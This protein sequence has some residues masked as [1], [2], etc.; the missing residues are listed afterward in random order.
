MYRFNDFNTLSKDPKSTPQFQAATGAAAREQTLRTVINHL[1]TEQKSY[2]DLHTTQ[3]TFMTPEL[4]SVYEIA[5]PQGWVPYTEPP[6]SQ[7]VGLLSQVSFLALHAH[8]GRSS[9]TLRG[10]ALRETLLCQEVPPPPPNVDFSVLNNPDANYPTQRD[11]VRA[12]LENPSC[13]GCHLIIDPIGLALENFDGE[14]RFRLRENG[15][16]IDASGELDG[17]EFDD[18]PGLAHALKNNPAL[19]KCLVQRMYYYSLGG[20]TV[21]SNERVA[22]LKYVNQ[23]FADNGYRLHDLLR[24]IVLSDAFS[25][26]TEPAATE[27]A[28][29]EV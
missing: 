21:P 28:G 15:A 22:F 9:A 12:H 1:V 17:I 11:R 24:T 4:A 29:E 5:T 25:R 2:L 18:A 3:S 26:I 19:P 14:G 6:D 7:R 8:P 16:M 13:A 20:P 10:T 23:E 27:P